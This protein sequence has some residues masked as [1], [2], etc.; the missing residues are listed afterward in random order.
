LFDE[1]QELVAL[2]QFVLVLI[3]SGNF[4]GKRDSD[5]QFKANVTKKF[6]TK[7]DRSVSERTSVDQA[8]LYRLTGDLNPLHIDSSFGSAMGFKKPIL[9]GLCSFGYAVKHIIQ[10]YCDN[11]VS[12]FKSV[13]VRFSKPV[14]PGETI[15]TNMWIDKEANDKVPTIYFE[16]KVIESG[17]I[18]LSGGIVKLHNF[19]DNS[20]D[21][22]SK[23]ETINNKPAE[24]NFISDNIF[25]EIGDRMKADP[26]MAKSINVIYAFNIKNAKNDVKTFVVDLKNNKLDVVVDKNEQSKVKSDCLIIISDKDFVELASGRANAQKM[27]LTGKLKVKGNIMLAQK[28]QKIFKAKSKL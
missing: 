27:F 3:G 26:Q 7:P 18:C 12:L 4:G 15:Q 9:H 6:T 8:A 22:V 23:E 17:N 28:L 10:E 5:H 25:K 14:Y 19:K 20:L 16:C 21:K 24:Q 13:K 2:N 1:K 11:D